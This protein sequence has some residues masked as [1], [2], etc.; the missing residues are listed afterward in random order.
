MTKKPQSIPSEAMLSTKST[1]NESA[2]LDGLAAA[3]EDSTLDLRMRL[4]SFPRQVMRQDIARFLTR[5]EIFKESMPTHGNIVECGVL[6]GGGLLS[7]MHFSTILEPYN[8]T[9]KVIGFDTFS[10]FPKIHDKDAVGSSQY[11]NQG[12]LGHASTTVEE[13]QKLIA[14]HDRNRP[15]SHLHKIELV[16]GDATDTIPKYVKDNPSLLISLLYLDFDLYEPTLIALQNLL[17]RVVV[18]GL[19][20][21]DEINCPEYPGETTAML[22]VIGAPALKRLPYDPMISYFVKESYSQVPGKDAK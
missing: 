17:P 18:G 14:L 12:G 3:F 9:R 10:G 13:L 5:Y 15:I 6:A 7:W 8:Y 21:F 16:K 1:S 19:V 2:I 11:L 22:E 20:V 4:R